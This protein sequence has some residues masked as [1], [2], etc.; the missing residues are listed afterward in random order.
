MTPVETWQPNAPLDAQ[1]LDAHLVDVELDRALAEGDA[2]SAVRWNEHRLAR[3]PE[4]TPGAHVPLTDVLGTLEDHAVLVFLSHR[5][6]L[7]AVSISGGRSRVHDFGEARTAA[8]YV[9]SLSLG[10]PP[11]AVAWLDRLLWPAGDRP[12]VVVPSPELERMPWAALPSA[13]GRA[14]SVA[15]SVRC[16][17]RADSRPLA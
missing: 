2:L 4:R 10:T 1:P 9:R 13:R 7:A 11:H 6:R 16:R 15:P 3:R 12:V 17:H 8:R 14:V 5:G